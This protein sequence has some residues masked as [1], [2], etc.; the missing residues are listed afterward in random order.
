MK[1]TKTIN[2]LE[3]NFH[4]CVARLVS[5]VGRYS[6]T[7]LFAGAEMNDKNKKRVQHSEHVI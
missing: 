2:P 7:H 1:L 3:K 4:T 6:N 5:T